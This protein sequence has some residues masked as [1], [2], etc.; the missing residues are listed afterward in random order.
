MTGILS[1]K[2]WYHE[3]CGGGSNCRWELNELDDEKESLYLKLRKRLS[4]CGFV[5]DDY[6]RINYG[7]QFNVEYD[8]RLHMVRIYEGKKGIRTDLSQIRDDDV[9]RTVQQCLLSAEAGG[10]GCGPKHVQDPVELIGTDESGKGDYFGPL[11]VA[12]VY[13]DGDSGCRLRSI[14]VT[15][16]KLL[17]DRQIARMAPV[18]MEC[19][20]YS[21]VSIP[22]RRYNE[23]Y[24]RIG[25]LN[26]LLGWGHARA[27]EDVL[28]KVDCGAALS[29]Q[30]G[31]R[32]LIED[33]LMERGR[34]I[35]LYQRPR[36]EENI[37]V[38]A[39]SVLA[40]Y[41]FFS[42]LD[43]IGKEYGM[44]FPKG[45]SSIVVDSAREFVSRYG[46]E[47][48]GDVAKL[49]FRITAEAKKRI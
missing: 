41:R 49:H 23:L 34:S 16:S 32:S 3:K 39:A 30:F 25:N 47:K 7:I 29:D 2:L 26:R 27:I 19:C 8:G 37:A 10:R 33:A 21:L 48:L 43:E 38:A 15:D 11:V 17:S 13:T 46:A 1:A 9:L 6:R 4:E 14:G 45:A 40:R 20:P 22:N 36:A 12:G 24:R 18:I 31:D 44:D 5:V 35:K 42:M 28:Q